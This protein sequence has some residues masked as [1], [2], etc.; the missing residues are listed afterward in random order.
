MPLTPDLPFPKSAGDAI[1]SKDWNDL[2]TE[3]QRLDNAKV[4]RAGDA[5]SGPLTIAGALGIGT[6]TPSAK[7]DVAGD[8]RINN[9]R[10]YLR[11]AGDNNHGLGWYGPGSPF[12]GANVDGPVLFGFSG[13]ALG[14]TDGG[15]KLALSWDD[16]GNVGMGTSTPKAALH[17]VGGTWLCDG[18]GYAVAN[19]RM[20]KGS[21]TVGSLTSSFGGGSGW[22]DNT[23]GL[24]FETRDDTE[25]A[26]HDSGTRIA[27]VA[28]YQSSANSL[29]IGRDMGWGPISSVSVAGSIRAGNSDLYFTKTDHNH[30]GFGNTPGFAA[31][32]NAGNYDALMILGR[33]G[34]QVPGKPAGTKARV[35]KL[36]DVLEV[37]GDLLVTGRIGSMNKGPGPLTAGWGGGL[38]TWDV[39]A[40]GTVWSRGAFQTGPR[41][42]AEI[43]FSDLELDP[44]DLV[45]LDPDADRIIRSSGPADPTVIGILSTEPGFLL[46]SQLNREAPA[47]DLR[48]YPV[49]L[50]GCVPC[51]VSDENGPIRRGDLLTTSSTPGHAMRAEPI[52]L[53]GKSLYPSGTIIGKA[54]AAHVDGEGVI[55]VFVVLR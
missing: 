20:A 22:S 31:I 40:E 14:S 25:I 44:G 39:E 52:L 18:T 9:S 5:I 43:Y 2:V 49:A 51:K 42:V 50:C 38:R 8:L 47:G 24:L 26:I 29:T 3:T 33:A 16:S 36:W 7:L 4:N 1:R 11:G 55:E 23:A 41:D 28:Y 30:S 13:G 6:T 35:V 46:N 21:L 54:L 12:A 27:S 53:D 48:P 17:V 32:E 45:S 37:N 19:N 15:Q 34:A 10:L